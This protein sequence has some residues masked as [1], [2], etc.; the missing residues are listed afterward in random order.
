MNVDSALVRAFAPSLK[1]PCLP[2]WMKIQNC[3]RKSIGIQIKTYKQ[4]LKLERTHNPPYCLLATRNPDVKQ[5]AWLSRS[6]DG[7]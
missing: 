1:Q 6:S 3:S 5:G 2:L 4:R 7:R